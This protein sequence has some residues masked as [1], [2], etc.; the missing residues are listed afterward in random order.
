MREL[1]LENKSGF[2]AGF[3]FAIYEKNGNL[4]Y[5]DTFTDK[6]EKGKQLYFNLPPGVYNYEGTIY[7]LETPVKTKEIN[8]PPFERLLPKK[9]YEIIF[10]ANPNKCTIFY[11]PGIILFDNAF[12]DAPLYIKFAI[13]FHEL[14]HHYYKT[15]KY[16]DLYAVKKMLEFG[17]NPSQ[18]GRTNIFSLREDKL[19]R[20]K[21]IIDKLTNN[22]S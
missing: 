19:E 6:I 18:I 15:E 20:K 16:A 17:F 12:K 3:P 9:R 11:K 14:G 13:Y 21:Y 1:K 10:G 8:L 5:S 22:E 4:F 2:R 7:K